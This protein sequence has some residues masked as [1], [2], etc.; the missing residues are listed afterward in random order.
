MA[1]TPLCAVFGFEG[2]VIGLRKPTEGTVF[3]KK[4]IEHLGLICATG[5]YCWANVRSKG[6]SQEVHTETYGEVK[7][8]IALLVDNVRFR[9]HV[10]FSYLV[11][12]QHW[13]WLSMYIR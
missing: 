2:G 5:K 9:A 7:R 13:D 4:N 3:L 1:N 10:K 11:E 8:F 12:S 6:W